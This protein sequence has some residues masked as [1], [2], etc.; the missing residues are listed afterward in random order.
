MLDNIGMA[1]PHQPKWMERCI[2]DYYASLWNAKWPHGPNGNDTYWGYVFTM[3]STEG[4]I[5]ALWS[6]HI[7]LWSVCSSSYRLRSYKNTV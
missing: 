5:H 2:R 6:A 7:D 3:G 1:F 4:I